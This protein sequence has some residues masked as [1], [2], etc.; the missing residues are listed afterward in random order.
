MKTAE[1]IKRQVVN[2]EKIN[3]WSVKNIALAVVAIGGFLLSIDLLGYGLGLIAGDTVAPIIQATSNP[4]VGLFIGL[5]M[6]AI[7]QSSSTTTSLA[8]AA[9]ASG[10]ISLSGALPI[11]L[12]ANVGTTITSTIVAFGYITK[13]NEFR[14]AVSAAMIHDMFN[15]L[16]VLIIFP[17]ELKYHFLQRMSSYLAVVM[18]TGSNTGSSSFWFARMFDTI[19][20]FLVGITGPIA[21]AVIS[22]LLLFGSIK[23][24]ST[25]VYGRLVG[26]SKQQFQ[27]AIFK[28]TGRAFG[29]GGLLT[30]IVQ[31]SSLTSS[32]I[33]PLVATGKVSL[34]R[35][36]HFIMGANIG[37]T[38]TAILAALFRSEEAMSLAITHFLF[39]TIAVLIFF[40]IPFIGRIPL[41]LAER[42]G[43]MMYRYR[44][45]AF[46]YITLA[47]FA[48]PF[49]L[50]YF[51]KAEPKAEPPKIE[52]KKEAD[53]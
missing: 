48:I 15:I 34:K 27:N 6:T 51:S 52:I 44:V 9:V 36:F 19:G 23:L 17:L 12:G 42:L 22:V 24:L 33:V 37:T 16:G 14:K 31:S 25:Q 4:F 50:I 8:V 35:A 40:S 7:L 41:F 2:L 28:N 20:E 13:G 45:S 29:W 1:L 21:L 3:I 26:K 30:A 53:N 43:Y 32:L 10:S 38:I 11:I 39:N 47:F 46:A 18:P 49:A 5:L